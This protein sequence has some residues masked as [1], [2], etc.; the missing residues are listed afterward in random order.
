MGNFVNRES[1]LGQAQLRYVEQRLWWDGLV[2]RRDV[3]TRFGCS[4]QHASAVLQ[5]YLE[6]NPKGMVYDLSVKRYV[7]HPKM[8]C[9]FEVSTLEEELEYEEDGL[10][11]MEFP[12]KVVEG[13]VKRALMVALRRGLKVKMKYQS[14][15]APMASWREISP[16]AFGYDGLRFHVRAWCYKNEEYRDFSLLRMQKVQWPTDEVAEELPQDEEWEEWVEVTVEVN[17]DLEEGTRQALLEDYEVCDGRIQIRC[18]K[19][20]KPYVLHRLGLGGAFGD[21]PLFSLPVGDRVSD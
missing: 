14:R 1:W 8:K 12:V 15:S 4:G 16:H 13:E 17:A 10:G 7:A 18:R 21:T 3:M 11:V 5:A 20:M 6:I 2:G 19:A 9:V